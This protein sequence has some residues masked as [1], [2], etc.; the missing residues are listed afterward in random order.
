M[1]P[2]SR[3]LPLVALAL[4]AG[5]AGVVAA[6]LVGAP[7][8][9][10]DASAGAAPAATSDSREL[11]ALQ[12][13]LVNTLALPEDF[14]T[15]PPFTLAGGDGEPLGESFLEGRWTLAFFGYTHCPDVC[16][17]TLQVMRQVVAE[18]ESRDVEPM[19]VAFFTVDPNRDTA[20]RMGEYVAFFDEDFVG[21][22]GEMS[23]V[24]ALTAE[25]GIVAS[26]TA[27]DTDPD[28]YL[29]DH[30]ASMLLIDPTRR[31]RAKFNPPHEADAIVA[32]YLTLMGA[33][34]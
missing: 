13:E 25:L 2:R 29:V 5:V 34:N 8:P 33:F 31:V 30:T 10:A 27:N 16:P 12:G 22:T 24:R 26:F 15:V 4:V 18:L 9:G 1:K 23:E 32:D 21:V 3:H 17:I 28:A 19:Q 14:R 6:S 11:Q 20:E 7:G